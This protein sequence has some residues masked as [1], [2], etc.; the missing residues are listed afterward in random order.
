MQMS[1]SMDLTG[2]KIEPYFN[3]YRVYAVTPDN[4]R[5]IALVISETDGTVY[6]FIVSR[7]AFSE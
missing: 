3:N 5:H 2:W 1:G 4:L 6:T 7:E